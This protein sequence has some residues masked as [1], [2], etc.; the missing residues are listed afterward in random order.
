MSH[1]ARQPVF[2]SGLYSTMGADSLVSHPSTR[3][4]KKTM[5]P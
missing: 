5:I 1:G 4:W 2:I 3:I